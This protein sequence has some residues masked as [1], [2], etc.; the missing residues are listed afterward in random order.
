M[1]V[2]INAH[3]VNAR[4]TVSKDRRGRASERE[5]KILLGKR[6]CRK[7]IDKCI[8]KKKLYIRPTNVPFPS[9]IAAYTG[10]YAFL[11]LHYY[12]SYY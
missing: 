9:L 5:R 3:R 7:R 1:E 8:R 6:I 11:L 10:R 12:C 4:A 2:R